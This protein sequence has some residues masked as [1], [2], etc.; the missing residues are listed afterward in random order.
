[1]PFRGIV[2]R[3]SLSRPEIIDDAK[4]ISTKVETVTKDMRTPWIPQ[5]TMEEIEVSD[6]AIDEFAK[7]LSQSIDRTHANSWYADLKNNNFHYIIFSGRV[8]S[9]DRSHPEQYQ[10]VKEFGQHIGI[11]KHQLDFV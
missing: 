5:W 10:A 4:V 11:P 1:M 9:V 3:E 8:F 6:H 2:I 7:K